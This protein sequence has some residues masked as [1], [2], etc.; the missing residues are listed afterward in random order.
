MAYIFVNGGK[1]YQKSRRKR[2]K[3][4]RKKRKKVRDKRRK[5]DARYGIP[6]QHKCSRRSLL[7][8]LPFPQIA[9]DL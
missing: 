4:N 9:K 6:L 8:N 7:I 2:T 3:K 1:K 5:I